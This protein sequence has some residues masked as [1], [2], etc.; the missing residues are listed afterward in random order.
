MHPSDFVG[1]EVR[2]RTEHAQFQGR[3]LRIEDWGIA[4]G[5]NFLVIELPDTG[6]GKK[7][8]RTIAVA[9]RALESFE[10]VMTPST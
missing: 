7:P 3:L 10:P 1:G 2:V 9:M 4:G 5:G 6:D 8:N